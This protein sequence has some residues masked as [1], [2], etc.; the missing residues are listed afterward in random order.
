[1]V[2]GRD[3]IIRSQHIDAGFRLLLRRARYAYHAS[4]LVPGVLYEERY[5]LPARLHRF[6]VQQYDHV[7]EAVLLVCH[8]DA[9]TSGVCDTRLAAVVAWL[10]EHEVG[11]LPDYFTRLDFDARSLALIRMIVSVKILHILVVEDL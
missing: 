4:A 2:L 6:S 7:V 5:L 1:M 9:R 11:V 8:R 3:P 10:T